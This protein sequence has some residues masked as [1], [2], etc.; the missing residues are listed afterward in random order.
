M[1]KTNWHTVDISEVVHA[2]KTDPKKGLDP[3]EARKRQ[4]E[5]GP[6]VIKETKKISPVMVFLEQFND[7]MIW[8]LIVA[9][10]IS[11]LLLGEI[12]D[13]VVIAIILFLNAI[14]GFVQTYKAEKS[15]EALKALS[16]PIATVIRSKEQE[17]KAEDLVPGDLILLSSGDIVPADARLIE[18]A[19][20]QTLEAPLTGE[21]TPVGKELGALKDKNIPVAERKNM[22]F[23]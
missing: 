6:N 13:A 1:N 16:A 5:H 10:L 3:E 17:I 4:E 9:A 22:V 23:S 18:V 7:F 11:G 8:V 20:F 14:L 2:L 12:V 15:L 21:S 19:S